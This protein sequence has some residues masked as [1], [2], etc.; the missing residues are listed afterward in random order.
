MGLDALF[1]KGKEESSLPKTKG[2]PEQKP[3]E[4]EWRKV[5]PEEYHSFVVRLANRMSMEVSIAAQNIIHKWEE[6]G[7]NNIDVSGAA[8]LVVRELGGKPNEV[9]DG[10]LNAGVGGGSSSQSNG[11]T[12]ASELPPAPAPLSSLEED[13]FDH[14]EDEGSE[15]VVLTV[16]GMKGVGKTTLAFSFAGEKET[17]ACLSFDQK[18]SSIKQKTYKG[19][20][21]IHVYNAVRYMLISTK[22]TILEEYN[23]T[24]RYILSLLQN[25]ITKLKPDWIVIDG[26]EEFLRVCEMV[27]R[28]RNDIQPFAGI[29]NFSLWKERLILLRRVHLIAC[30][31]ARKGI[32]YTTYVRPKEQIYEGQTMSKR[33]VP[34]WVDYIK[35]RTDTL[36]RVSA[37][38]EKDGKYRFYAF[39]ETSKTD[40]PTGREFDVT[41]GGVEL[42]RQKIREEQEMKPS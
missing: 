19:D 20:K 42:I 7:K 33:D 10:L 4:K 40:L 41:G 2:K 16:Y 29:G 18:S 24:Y 17:I 38:L 34:K 8:M 12:P 3:E 9:F 39:I 27:M 5:I 30:G 13:E 11:V 28:Y 35:E 22:A 23:K 37:R 1:D 14:S 21:R 25:P 15:I 36:I 26:T 32:I 6:L 31:I